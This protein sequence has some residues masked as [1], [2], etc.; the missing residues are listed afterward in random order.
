MKRTVLVFLL[1]VAMVIPVS[2]VSFA[3]GVSVELKGGAFIPTRDLDDDHWDNGLYGELAGTYRES[4]MGVQA[5]VGV[6]TSDNNDSYTDSVAGRVK[7]DDTLTVI[8]VTLSF[9]GFYDNE[10][11]HVYGGGGIGYYFADID[12]ELKFRDLGIKSKDS[13]KDSVF[14]YH[15]MAGLEYNITDNIYIG[16]EGRFVFTNN[17]EFTLKDKGQT[18][19]Y[20]TDLSGGV[21]AGK[22]GFRF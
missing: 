7:R 9:L 14:G 22:M 10:P 19:D 6:Y 4:N 3:Q 8:P 1:A 2:G 12:S 15:A 13:D 20:E 17:A 5:G 21:I 18:V 11:L 16:A